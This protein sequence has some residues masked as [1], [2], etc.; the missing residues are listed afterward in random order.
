MSSL[1]QL[2]LIEICAAFLRSSRL[3]AQQLG[4]YS[5]PLFASK[6][7]GLKRGCAA[8]RLLR[9]QSQAVYICLPVLIGI[10]PTLA[11]SVILFASSSVSN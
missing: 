3:L 1:V 9:M 5:T 7:K 10:V 4:S 6:L 11:V 8:P 2:M